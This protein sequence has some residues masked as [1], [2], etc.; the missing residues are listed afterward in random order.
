MMLGMILLAAS[1]CVATG[2]NPAAEVMADAVCAL[3][4][5]KTVKATESGNSLLIEAKLGEEM[6]REFRTYPQEDIDKALLGICIVFGRRILKTES[7]F[8]WEIKG[9]DGETLVDWKCPDLAP[10]G[11]A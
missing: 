6:T 4:E 8:H 1:T 7:V 11:P 5:A 9:S 10:G 2:N 3:L